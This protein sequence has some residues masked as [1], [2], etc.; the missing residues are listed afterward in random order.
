MDHYLAVGYRLRD[1]KRVR[2]RVEADSLASAKAYFASAGDLCALRVRR[3][4]AVLEAIRPNFVRTPRQK[5]LDTV[6]RSLSICL[7]AGL[8][9]LEALQQSRSSVSPRSG[10]A[11]VLNTM[12]RDVS[13]DATIEEAFRRQE[14]VFGKHTTAVLIAGVEAGNLSEALADMGEADVVASEAVKTLRGAMITPAFLLVQ[15]LVSLYV[16]MKIVAPQFSRVMAVQE[17]PM[18]WQTSLV[19]SANA[20][21]DSN[22]IA[23]LLTILATMAAIWF[24]CTRSAVRLVLSRASLRLPF[25]GRLSRQLSMSR[26]CNTVGVM[27]NAHVTPERIFRYAAESVKNRSFRHRARRVPEL[28]VNR[29]MTDTDALRA[30]RMDRMLVALSEQTAVLVSKPGE[31]WKRYAGQMARDAQRASSNMAKIIQPLLMTIMALA[32]LFQAFVVLGPSM[33]MWQSY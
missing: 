21:I 10:A 17:V 25:L 23:I 30:C 9:P 32:V 1:G 14:D 29:G 11:A 24:V 12:E 33:A 19:I 20:F 27:K 13:S 31:P 18:P 4:P 7:S 3:V 28:M 26:Y 8:D 5:D 6:M 2:R 15:V 16:T 22:I